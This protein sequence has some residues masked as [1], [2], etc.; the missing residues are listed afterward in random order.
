MSALESGF[1]A[2]GDVKEMKVINLGENKIGILVAQNNGPLR[3]FSV[4]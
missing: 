3:L 4:K 1:F 2:D